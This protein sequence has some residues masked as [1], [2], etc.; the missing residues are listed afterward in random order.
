MATCQTERFL[1]SFSNNNNNEKEYNVSHLSKN[2]LPF[3]SA[4]PLF[5]VSCCLCPADTDLVEAATLE[6]SV[7]LKILKEK[8]CSH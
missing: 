2:V 6:T 7:W 5:V 3:M 4:E 1:I 8:K